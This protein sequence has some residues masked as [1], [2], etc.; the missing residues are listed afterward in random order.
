MQKFSIIILSLVIL[1]SFKISAQDKPAALI[2]G[3]SASV[4][5]NLIKVETLYPNL[6]G[7]SY[8]MKIRKDISIYNMIGFLGHYGGGTISQATY[9]VSSYYVLTPQVTVQPRFYHNLS[10]RAAYDKNTKFNSANYVGISAR[11][12]DEGI[13]FSNVENYPKGPAFFD[14]MLSYGLQ[15][16]FFKRVNWDMAIE[17]GIEFYD[18][19]AAFFIGLKLQLGFVVFSN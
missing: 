6:L 9:G 14:L 5:Q 11:F 7:V 8:E 16:T 19:Q 2:K 3:E 10:E 15:R 12:Y 1:C 17:P 4:A 18:G 13:F